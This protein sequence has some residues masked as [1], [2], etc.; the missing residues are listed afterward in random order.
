M[1]AVYESA[2]QYDEA[3]EAYKTAVTLDRNPYL[4]YLSMGN[5]YKKTKRYESAIVSYQ[6]VIRIADP[7][8]GFEAPYNSLLRCYTDSGRLADGIAYF[9]Q[10]IITLGEKPIVDGLTTS[11]RA[12]Y[13]LGMM[14]AHSGD[15]KAALDQY[16]ILKAQG[17]GRSAELAEKL[18][19]QIYGQ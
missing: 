6:Q 3:I 11:T 16:K 5:I 18:F 17:N 12:H 9:K 8:M 15:S 2:G 19:N 4:S 10:L 1:A 13:A 14:Y 7:R